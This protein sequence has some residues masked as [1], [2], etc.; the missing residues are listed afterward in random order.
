MSLSGRGDD[1]GSYDRSY[2]TSVDVR[3]KSFLRVVVSPSFSRTRTQNQYVTRATDPL[4]TS[5]FGSRYLFAAVDQRTFSL[6]TR[7]NWTFTPR[8]T[9]ELVAQP[10]VASGAYSEFKE[11]TTPRALHFSRFGVD[12]S[13]TLRRDSASVVLDPDGA[14][15]ALPIVLGAPDFTVRSLRGSAVM[16]WE[17]RPGSTLF[18]VWQQQRSGSSADGTLSAG[19]FGR[20]FREP[21][22][23][24]FL[25]KAS[26]WLSK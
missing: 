13:S 4:A 16:R 23:N 18:F 22:Q 20:A 2:Y 15:A 25:V 5:T 21:G 9:L 3:P 19:D 10:F 8:L 11:F 24:V 6:S 26:Y 14:G 17:Y 7:V 12:G 1:A